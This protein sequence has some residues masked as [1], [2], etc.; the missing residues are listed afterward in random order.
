MKEHTKFEN[1]EFNLLR[2]GTTTNV[3]DW[4]YCN[5]NPLKDTI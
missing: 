5:Y 4:L 2:N 1:S 3:R